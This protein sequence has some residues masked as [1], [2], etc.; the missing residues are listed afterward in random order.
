M[1]SGLVLL[2]LFGGLEPEVPRTW[3][4]APRFMGRSTGALRRQWQLISPI[5]AGQTHG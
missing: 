4:S 3:P 5:L 1:E 2:D